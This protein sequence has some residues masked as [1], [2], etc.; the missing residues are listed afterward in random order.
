MAKNVL[1]CLVEQKKELK[2]CIFILFSLSTKK[3]GKKLI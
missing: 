1:E 3:D 2:I